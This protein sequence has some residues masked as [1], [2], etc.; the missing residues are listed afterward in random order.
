[1]DLVLS[2]AGSLVLVAG[3]ASLKHLD[4]RPDLSPTS[5]RERGT[6]PDVQNHTSP[7]SGLSTTTFCEIGVVLMTFH[8]RR[9][10]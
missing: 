8:G 3:Q 2:P 4:D 7:G 6:R 5:A 9:F 10:I 1:M